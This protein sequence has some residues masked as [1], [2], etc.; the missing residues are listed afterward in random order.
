MATGLPVV[1]ARLEGV[2]T[3]MIRSND[4][5]TL[6]T[7]HDPNTYAN[8][9]LQL[10]KDPVRAGNMGNAARARSASEFNLEVIMERFARLYRELA[11]VP[12]A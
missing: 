10:L 12:H 7:G 4:E 8:A 2:T 11:G 9:L 5:G 6:I 1:A 3:D